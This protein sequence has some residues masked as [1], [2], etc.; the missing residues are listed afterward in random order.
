MKDDSE[1]L[2]T[3][4]RDA[5]E[6]TVVPFWLLSGVAIAS[7]W[8]VSVPANTSDALVATLERCLANGLEVTVT[9]ES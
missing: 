1:V 3:I 5:A 9:R 4:P 2:L 7:E 8:H 6:N